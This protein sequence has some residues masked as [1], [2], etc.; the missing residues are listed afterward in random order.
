MQTTDYGEM[1]IVDDTEP[2]I[3]Y[4]SGWS[5]LTPQNNEYYNRTNH[6]SATIGA[7][8]EYTFV[9]TGIMV[10]DSMYR[11]RGIIEVFIDG[12]SQESW[13]KYIE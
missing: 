11:S 2:S 13:W 10:Y 6:T 9:G 8:L 1:K 3:N 12:A 5:N 4:V 7:S